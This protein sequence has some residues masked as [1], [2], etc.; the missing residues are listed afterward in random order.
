LVASDKQQKKPETSKENL[1]E[2][3]QNF[4]ISESKKE[5]NTLEISAE[6]SNQGKVHHL[7]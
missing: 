2:F 5:I 3:S 6:N 7:K 4:S 1:E